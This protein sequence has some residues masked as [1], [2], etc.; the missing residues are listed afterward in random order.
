MK[1]PKQKIYYHFT[2]NT[3]RNGQPIPPVGKWLKHKGN[4]VP[5]ESGLHASEHP[6]DALQFAPG[7]M[8]HRVVLRGKVIPHGNPIDKVC[9]RERKIVATINADKMCRA[10]AR[11][12]A[13]DVSDKWDAPKIVLDYLR[14]GDESLRDAARDA[15]SARVRSA[16]WAAAWTSAWDVA[17]DAASASARDAASAAARDAAWASAWAAIRTPV[18]TSVWATAS[19]AVR[20]SVWDVASDAAW[21]AAFQKYR[22]WFAE[23]VDAEFAKQT[24]RIQ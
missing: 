8:L 15:A 1:K 13:L 4:L 2:G 6:I 20:T 17:W 21:D 14:T 23:M 24:K 5:C 22:G 10:F 18:R 16:A 9:A 19:D 12:V 3:L 7:H 11:R